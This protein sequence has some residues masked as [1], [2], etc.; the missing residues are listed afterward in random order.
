MCLVHA[1]FILPFL[2]KQCV[3]MYSSLIFIYRKME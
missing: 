3:F 2:F 1:G